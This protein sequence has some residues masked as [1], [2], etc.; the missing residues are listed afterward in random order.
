EIEYLV[1][2]GIVEGHGD[3]RFTP[4][5]SVTRAQF[6]AMV[7]RALDFTESGDVEFTDVDENAWYYD[8][9]A[10]AVEAGFIQGHGGDAEG[11]FGPLDPITREQ[12]AT[13]IARAYDLE[14]SE[15]EADFTDA[16]DIS[17]YAVGFVNAAAEA[18]FIEGYPEGDYK[19]QRDITRAQSAV[20]L[21]R[22][23]NV[24]EVEE[25]LEIESVS[26]ID[27]TGVEV[28]F[29]ATTEDNDEANVVVKDEEGN[30]VETK[31]KLLAEGATSATF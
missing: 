8:D 28:V 13:M 12:A 10:I 16:D 4:N 17:D 7:N 31:A 26:V 2:E 5:S 1:E 29:E 20:I 14:E 21:Y 30:V 6:A 22:V 25:E 3:G 18:G 27:S 9:V 11:T 24:E 23:M 19:P 15:E